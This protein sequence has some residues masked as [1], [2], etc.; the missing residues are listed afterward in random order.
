MICID[1]TYESLKFNVINKNFNPEEPIGM[2]NYIFEH[3]FD[4]QIKLE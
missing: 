3:S 1:Y 2:N 4:L